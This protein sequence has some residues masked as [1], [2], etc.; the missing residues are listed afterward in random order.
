MTNKLSAT[1]MNPSYDGA[2][3]LPGV[4]QQNHTYEPLNKTQND[5]LNKG[6]VTEDK[7]VELRNVEFTELVTEELTDRTGPVMTPD[8]S[9]RYLQCEHIAPI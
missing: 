7:A 6:Q 1:L 4:R 2:N 3:L 8:D 9:P 5:K